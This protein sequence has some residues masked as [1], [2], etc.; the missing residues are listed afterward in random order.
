MKYGNIY[1]VLIMAVLAAINIVLS[2]RL[3]KIP[4]RVRS[5]LCS[6]KLPLN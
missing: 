6:L 3:F 1:K 2:M 4:K 5:R